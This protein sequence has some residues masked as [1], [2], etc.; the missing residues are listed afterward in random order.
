MSLFQLIQKPVYQVLLFV[1]MTVLL[2]LLTRPRTSDKIWVIAGLMYSLFILTNSVL[3]FF[4]TQLWF[5]LMVSIGCSLFYLLV[6]AFVVKV[7]IKALKRKG[8]E[9]SSM[10]FLVVIFHP[11]LLLS[12]IFVRWIF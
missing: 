9:E 4:E 8:T 6:I 1:L 5:Y 3:L 10:I 2:A 12:A 11:G 7:L